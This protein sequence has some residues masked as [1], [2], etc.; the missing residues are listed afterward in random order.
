LDSVEL[1]EVEILWLRKEE[2]EK[3]EA[4]IGST[5]KSKNIW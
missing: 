4:L 3:K 2:E 1:T 5:K